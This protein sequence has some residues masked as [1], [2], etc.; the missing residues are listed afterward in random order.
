MKRR[1][2][3]YA[4]ARELSIAMGSKQAKSPPN[5]GAGGTVQHLLLRTPA[6]L[7]QA[8]TARDSLKSATT[9]LSEG[10]NWATS[11][12]V[13]E[14]L[15]AFASCQVHCIAY[16]CSCRHWKGIM[17]C[18]E[19]RSEKFTGN[20]SE[21]VCVRREISCVICQNGE[22]F[23]R[24]LSSQFADIQWLY[25]KRAMPGVHLAMQLN[26]ST[27]SMCKTTGNVHK[28]HVLN[29]HH[30]RHICQIHFPKK[31][32]PQSPLIQATTALLR[33]LRCH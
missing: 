33:S 19:P 17:D 11:L 14:Y 29:G 12:G 7:D 10:M 2:T 22:S 23:S 21:V 20:I 25:P 3:R 27:P 13:A 28:V 4:T 1:S 18:N 16:A 5:T 31:R 24:R 6:I 26:R 30:D 15:L 32:Y 9:S 8:S